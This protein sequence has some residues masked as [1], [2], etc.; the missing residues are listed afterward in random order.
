MP[1]V[2]SLF[3]GAAA[4]AALTGGAIAALRH[5]VFGAAPEGDR[6]DR[7]KRSPQWR[8]GAFRN[9]LPSFSGG[10]PASIWEWFFGDKALRQP[11]APVPIVR[12]TR[13]DFEAP[14]GLRLTWLGHGTTL[15]EIEG[16]RFLID[17]LFSRNASPGPM[18]GVA[19]FHDPPLPLDELPDLDAVVLTHDHYDHLDAATVRQLAGRVP[20][21]I[22]PLG[23]GA[24]LE[25]WGVAPARIT[26]LDWW[27]RAEVSGIELVCTPARHFSGRGLTDRNRTLWSG[28]AFLGAE[29]RVYATGDGGMQRAFAEVGERLGPFDATLV[30]TGA[31]NADWADIHMGPEQAVRAVQDAQGG[32]LIPIHWG[33]FNLA[34]H[35]WTEPAERVWVAAEAAGVELAIPKP[36]ESVWPEEPQP[37]ARWWPERPWTTAE[38]APVVSSGM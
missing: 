14:Q 10:S 6:L 9:A 1:F 35:G 5:P 25:R 20:R 30:E 17:P 38:E 28:W 21:W 12:R 27:E 37:V 34:F 8:D 18:F 16:K 26:E 32:L 19:R 33:T 2:R 22:T 13:A 11:D 4:A 3:T 7:M 15:I 24:H 36:G 29:K 31:Y 23:V